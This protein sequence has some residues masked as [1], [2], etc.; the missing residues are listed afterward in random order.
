MKDLKDLYIGINSEVI[1]NKV[2]EIAA[3]NAKRHI[4]EQLASSYQGV[5]RLFV[6]FF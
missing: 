5:K 3:A 6:K 2:V 1:D 4:R